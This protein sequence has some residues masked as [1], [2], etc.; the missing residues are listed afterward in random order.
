MSSNKI[1]RR[2]YHLLKNLWKNDR[3][4]F[5]TKY[6]FLCSLIFLTI[7][8]KLT[9]E[10]RLFLYFQMYLF[11]FTILLGVITFIVHQK[12]I[13]VAVEKEQNF[14]LEEEK[15]K[16]IFDLKFPKIA[17]IPIIGTIF[18]E[19][20]K[21]GLHY[22]LALMIIIFVG[23]F[24]RIFGL[25]D[26]NFRGD[27]F[28]VMRAATT[29][30]F[31]KELYLWDWINKEP[32]G[33]LYQRAWPHTLL[34]AKAFDI[35][36]ISEWSARLVS[37]I[38]G[39]VFIIMSYFI[40]KYFTNNKKI[41]LLTTYA[42]A[43]NPSY[44][45]LSRYTRMYSLLF[46][47]FLLLA[48]FFYRGITEGFDLR[49]KN[50]FIR[51]FVSVFNFNYV[52]LFFG[53]LLLY[54][55]Y[56]I[57]LNSLII[58]P[59]LLIFLLYLCISRKEK[60][61]ILSLISFVI[62]T[63][64]LYQF[65]LKQ[66][67]I[68]ELGKFIIFFK[69][70]FYYIGYLSKYPFIIRYSFDSIIGKFGFIFLIFSF[71]LF[72]LIRNRINKDRIAYLMS[73]II[74]TL[75]FFIF[76]ANRYPSYNYTSHITPF[77]IAL[78][79]TSFYYFSR[80]FTKKFVRILVILFLLANISY[81]FYNSV[82]AIYSQENIYGRFSEAYESILMNFDPEKD[83]IF[84]LQLRGYYLKELGDNVTVIDMPKNRN[85]QFDQFL[86]DINKYESGWITWESRKRYH[87]RIEII[88]FI[89]NNFEHIN[90][91]QCGEKIDDNRVEVFYFNKTMT[92]SINH[93]LIQN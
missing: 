76:L 53:G 22:S 24:V 4:K 32:A 30:H 25:G 5:L 85:Y 93:T 12:E 62:M 10:F 34:V 1:K 71:T 18:N 26:F 36:G 59:V 33:V 65:F 81:S 40:I 8:Q 54:I 21:E 64:F 37:V 48:Y 57:H 38:F 68:K 47:I 89:C 2:S 49:L 88:D 14:R 90:G 55:G 46:P 86:K 23:F 28:L 51:K 19:I 74:F 39:T 3:L 80:F 79:I 29:Y 87:L 70:N 43:L 45:E 67:F 91:H 7:I 27:E 6:A 16:K 31:K 52:Y 73:L 75:F 41:A 13:D 58:L 42:F 61:F 35:F 56:V 9:H 20:Y 17:Q 92:Q 69:S 83:V 63:F 50:L 60:K 78:I 77:S 82:G 44:V 11:M 66:I 72:L 15:R 84:G